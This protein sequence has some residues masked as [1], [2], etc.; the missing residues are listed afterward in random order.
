MLVYEKL[1][2]TRNGFLLIL[3]HCPF[4]KKYQN[5]APLTLISLHFC[6]G[7]GSY[8]KIQF[9]VQLAGSEI[10]SENNDIKL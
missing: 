6:S 4:L 5:F 7:D 9:F 1:D 3:V 10:M 8:H 2:F